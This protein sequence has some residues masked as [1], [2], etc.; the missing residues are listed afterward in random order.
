MDKKTKQ[1]FRLFR[2]PNL[3]RRTGTL[4]AGSPFTLPQTSQYRRTH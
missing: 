4:W 1:P 3:L 2:F